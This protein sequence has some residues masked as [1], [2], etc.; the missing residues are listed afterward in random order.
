MLSIILAAASIVAAGPAPAAGAA[1][2]APAPSSQAAA[3]P[4]KPNERRVKLVCREETIPNSHFTNRVCMD[5]DVLEAEEKRN[6][7]DFNEMQA[8]ARSIPLQGMGGR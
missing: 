4:L 7:R 2:A 3:T 6:Q 8:R 1:A 5:K